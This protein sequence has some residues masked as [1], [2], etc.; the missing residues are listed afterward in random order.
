MKNGLF[1]NTDCNTFGHWMV[2]NLKQNKTWN[3]INKLLWNNSQKEHTAVY[4]AF[5]TCLITSAVYN[6]YHFLEN[7]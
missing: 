7:K 3:R 6:V 5:Y 1:R 4:K 2:D